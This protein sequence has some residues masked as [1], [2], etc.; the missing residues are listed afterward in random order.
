MPGA[1]DSCYK[2]K[3]QCDAVQ[4]QCNWC[5][6]HKIACTFS[7]VPRTRKSKIP[8]GH[9]K[10]RLNGQGAEI[11]GIPSRCSKS[12]TEDNVLQQPQPSHPLDSETHYQ[13]SHQNVSQGTSDTKSTPSLPYVGLRKLHFAGVELGFMGHNVMPFFSSRGQQWVQSCTGDIVSSQKLLSLG[14]LCHDIRKDNH[15]NGALPFATAMRKQQQIDLPSKEVV[16]ECAKQFLASGI[17]LIFPLVDMV[18]FSDALSLA[19]GQTDCSHSWPDL[20]NARAFILSFLALVSTSN[21]ECGKLLDHSGEV[22]SSEAHQLIPEVLET[23]PSLNGVQSIIM[24]ALNHTLSGDFGSADIFISIASRLIFTLGGHINDAQDCTG[25]E[26]N[27]P[28]PTT[29]ESR[30]N[31]H[32]RKLFWICYISDKDSCVRI[33]RP[34]SLHDSECDLTLPEEYGQTQNAS[35]NSTSSEPSNAHEYAHSNIIFLS[36]IRLSILK[37]HIQS[38][39]YSILA[40]RKTDA[41]LLRSVRELD[42]E[43]EQWRVSLPADIRPTVSFSQDPSN[44]SCNPPGLGAVII[45]LEYHHCMGTIHQA[46]SR[47]QAWLQRPNAA[48][49]GVSSSLEL[50]IG[51]SR[52]LLNYLLAAHRVLNKEFFRY[53]NFYPMSAF[54]TLFCN[55]LRKPLHASVQGDLKLLEEGPVRLRQV[56]EFHQPSNDAV[57]VLQFVEFLVLLGSLARSAMEKARCESDCLEDGQED[58]K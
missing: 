57:H 31:T 42:D 15:S 39:L 29:H 13:N 22:W 34:P 36:E 18:L 51:A 35:P 3:I 9:R 58:L 17:S 52:S 1:C 25:G 53:I 45:R 48:M 24:I 10:K 37:S 23:S 16:E 11:T 50:S 14:L 2:R 54:L 38:S 33:A 28:R 4:P 43:L 12:E 19:Y 32:I 20:V 44:S 5:H 7:R 56:M 30:V 41:E 55:M 49:D 6:H 26:N 27:P 8:T 40:L 46:S 47:C 21:V